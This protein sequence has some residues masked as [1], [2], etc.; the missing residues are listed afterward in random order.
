MDFIER[1]QGLSLFSADDVQADGR[2][3]KIAMMSIAPLKAFTPT[4]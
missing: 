1:K 3:D 4:R 2:A